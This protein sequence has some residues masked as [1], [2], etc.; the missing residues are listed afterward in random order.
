MVRRLE[1]NKED[2]YVQLL[3][4]CVD[5]ETVIDLIHKTVPILIN[6]K[7]KGSAYL[8]EFSEDSDSVEIIERS[9]G[10]WIIESDKLLVWLKNQGITGARQW[11]LLEHILHF[12]AVDKS[13]YPTL[14]L[15]LFPDCGTDAVLLFCG[16]ASS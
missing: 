10:Y 5:R 13:L 16:N 1:R 7:S 3:D 2:L 14:S 8:S 12:L 11:E 15:Y 9:Y 6:E 4:E